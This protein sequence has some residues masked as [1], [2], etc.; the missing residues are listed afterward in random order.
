MQLCRVVQKLRVQAQSRSPELG[1]VPAAQVALT[2]ASILGCYTYSV[3]CAADLT[4]RLLVKILLSVPAD[5]TAVG[6]R[7]SRALPRK[8]C[9]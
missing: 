1:A 2:A 8:F 5:G 6:V 4:L 9:S 7:M 3:S